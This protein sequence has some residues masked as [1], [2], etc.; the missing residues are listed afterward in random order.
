MTLYDL[1]E[2]KRV[3]LAKGCELLIDDKKYNISLFGPKKSRVEI[4]NWLIEQLKPQR[5]VTAGVKRVVT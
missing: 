3:C 5:S 4:V 2:L 1:I